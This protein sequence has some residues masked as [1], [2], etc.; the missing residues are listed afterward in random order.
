M[1]SDCTRAFC[2]V[3]DLAVESARGELL[4]LAVHRTEVGKV[5]AGEV[6]Y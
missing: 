2:Q 1:G 3:L 4:Q 5:V 6:P